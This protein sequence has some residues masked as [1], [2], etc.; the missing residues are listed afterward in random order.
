[1][2]GKFN[3]F[4]SNINK[5]HCLAINVN[6]STHSLNCAIS[7]AYNMTEIRDCLSI[8]SK[9]PD[10]FIYPKK[11]FV[12]NFCIERFPEITKKKL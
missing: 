7:K 12:L 9:V 10:F 2:S 3:G 1:M 5:T 8:L 11:K 4:Q 6:S